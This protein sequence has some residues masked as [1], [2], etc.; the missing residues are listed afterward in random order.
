MKISPRY[1]EFRWPE[2]IEAPNFH[3]MGW[4]RSAGKQVASTPLD[5]F[6]ALC[7]VHHQGAN[8]YHI[9]GNQTLFT[10]LKREHPDLPERAA[11]M[12]QG[13][14]GDDTKSLMGVV[15]LEE[16]I[17]SQA[18]PT[19]PAFQLEGS[20]EILGLKKLLERAGYSLENMMSNRRANY[21]YGESPGKR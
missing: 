7:V 6:K 12:V 8:V 18:D 5:L 11:F 2:H 14:L 13:V 10:A 16:F 19:Y 1:G 20:K 15:H 4:R 9:M 21:I 3:T 17:N